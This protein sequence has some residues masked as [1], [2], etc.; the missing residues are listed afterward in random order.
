VLA[1]SRSV[2]RP[3]QNGDKTETEH[4][5][6]EKNNRLG[7]VLG[8]SQLVKIIATTYNNYILG[9]NE[10]CEAVKGKFNYE[11]LELRYRGLELFSRK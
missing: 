5:S 9:Y 8:R 10:K 2:S 1:Q 11:N 6:V 7:L 3:R 4:D